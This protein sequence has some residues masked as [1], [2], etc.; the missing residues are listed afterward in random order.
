MAGS[1]MQDTK[2]RNRPI[3]LLTSRSMLGVLKAA[4]IFILI[5][6]PQLY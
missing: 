1:D 3:I 6:T 2:L 4:D 5:A